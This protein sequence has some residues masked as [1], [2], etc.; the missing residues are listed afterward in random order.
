MK[1]ATFEQA[2]HLLQLVIDRQL[3]LEKLQLVYD[4]GLLS[5]LLEVKDATKV[6]REEY[7]KVIGLPP[8]VPPPSITE[9]AEMEVNYTRTRDQMIAAGSYDWT[10]SDIAKYWPEMKDEKRGKEM[11][12]PVTFHFNRDISSEA[13]IAEM[14]KAGY[15]PATAV[16]ILA[17]GENNPKV[18][19]EFPVVALGFVAIV[20][21]DR[22][23]VFLDRLGSKRRL[24]L[25]W[26]GDGWVGLFRFLAVRKTSGA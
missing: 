18:Q 8:L 14:D 15:R 11:V 26:F 5:D 7:R 25:A 21:D 19:L 4:S 24:G 16:E 23:V 3:S 6:D 13:A 2:S 22:R 10:N 17:F 1:T 9:Y 20:S 12:K